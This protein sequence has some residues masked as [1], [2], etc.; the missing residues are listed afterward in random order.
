MTAFKPSKACAFAGTPP[1]SVSQLFSGGCSPEREEE[2]SADMHLAGSDL[3]PLGWNSKAWLAVNR[4]GG[5]VE[6]FARVV[7]GFVVVKILL[8]CEHKSIYIIIFA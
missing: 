1:C 6:F 3:R 7:I 5:S 4:R 2:S 8:P